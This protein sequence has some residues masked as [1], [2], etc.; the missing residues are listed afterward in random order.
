[1]ISIF[2]RVLFAAVLVALLAA[3]VSA[4]SRR[5]ARRAGGQRRAAAAATPAAPTRISIDEV[6]PGDVTRGAKVTLTGKFPTAEKIVV[7][8]RLT[9]WAQTSGATGDTTGKEAQVIKPEPVTVNTPTATGDATAA[10]PTPPPAS[11]SFA[12]PFNAPLGRYQITVSFTPKGAEAQTMV[13]PISPDGMLHVVT[14]DPVKIEAVFPEVGYP[15]KGRF[16]LMV[17]GDGFSH[18]A[19]DNALVIE[20]QERE[21]LPA[22]RGQEPGPDCVM[23]KLSDNDRDLTFSEIPPGD[24]KGQ[25][26][27]QVRVGDKY[28]EKKD[29][30]LARVPKRYPAT[31]AV[32]SVL[33]LGSLVVW[34]LGRRRRAVTG[35]RFPGIPSAIFLDT[36]TNTYSLSKFQ[37]YLWTGAAL[38]G[39]IYLTVSKSW[40]QWDFTFADIPERLPGIIFIAASTTIASVGIT[41]S[42]GSKGAGELQPSFADFFTS[43]GVVAAERLQF[44]VWTI[45][46]VATFIFLTLST[47]PA[48]IQKLPDVPERFLYLMGIS[49]FGYLGGKLARKPGP[50]VTKIE[51]EAGS[52]TL[53]VHGSSLSPDAVFRIDDED[54]PLR[55][56]SDEAHPDGRP[57]V[58]ATDDQ[59]GFAKVLRIVIN[60]TEE[61]QQ[62]WLTGEHTFTIINP[63]GQ[64]AAWNFT[65]APVLTQPESPAPGGATDHASGQAAATGQA[66]PEPEKS[67]ADTP[68]DQLGAATTMPTGATTTTP[69][70]GP[71]GGVESAAQTAGAP[72][73]TELS[74]TSG[75][76]DG[77]APVIIMGANFSPSAAVFFGESQSVTVNVLSP[78]SLVAQSPPHAAGPVPVTVRNPDGGQATSRGSYTYEAVGRTPEA[79]SVQGG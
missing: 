68:L 12:V 60:A 3:T 1:M 72:T 2:K 25:L 36:A 49:S 62:K 50:V 30:T 44:F 46:G 74:P 63:D 70:G 45:I 38:F 15:I 10:P 61:G 40:V 13:V 19:E 8:L 29:V 32:V 14:K 69:A 51:A 75:P 4:Q 78:G 73:I 5:T 24:R 21:V 42:K 56:M 65:A 52:L 23:V 41:S 18:V 55:V 33:L 26:K 67:P 79:E 11:L 71:T 57:E 66:Q 47:E 27:I 43:G 9:E 28:S 53:T 31:I 34:V 77:N 54:I 7:E 48:A 17:R 37:F 22:C 64:K 20:G 59:P 58:V 6:A 39:Y 35:G 16:S 76:T